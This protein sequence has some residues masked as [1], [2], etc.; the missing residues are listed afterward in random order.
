MD[1]TPAFAREDKR[2]AA[3]AREV[4]APIR[5]YCDLC[6]APIEPGHRRLL[7]KSAQAI[8]CTCDLCA[9]RVE[10]EHLRPEPATPEVSV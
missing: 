9:L 1:L 4:G 8:L 6:R 10:L 2:A 5:E 7:R 3:A